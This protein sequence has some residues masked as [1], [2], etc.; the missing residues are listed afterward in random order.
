MHCTGFMFKSHF[1]TVDE[2]SHFHLGMKWRA[3]FLY[4]AEQWVLR[5]F[6]TSSAHIIKVVTFQFITP[7]CK[8]P[9]NNPQATHLEIYLNPFLATPPPIR[10]LEQ[11][12]KYEHF[13]GVT[14]MRFVVGE[15]GF[16]LLLE[17]GANQFLSGNSGCFQRLKTW[18]Y[19]CSQK[20]NY[21]S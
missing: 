11:R 4:W 18:N 13:D 9:T 14:L 20:L 17:S 19:Y 8:R 10:I 15:S 3:E 21:Y 6:F 16:V 2:E 7:R 12:S 1:W 5:S